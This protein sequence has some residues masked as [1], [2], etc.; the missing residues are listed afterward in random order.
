MIN[1]SVISSDIN[2]VIQTQSHIIRPLSHSHNSTKFWQ[3][4]EAGK[5]VH[6]TNDPLVTLRIESSGM[7]GYRKCASCF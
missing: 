6:A 4:I 5:P 7:N 3:P 1:V 2:R